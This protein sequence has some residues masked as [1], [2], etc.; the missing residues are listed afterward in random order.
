MLT[1]PCFLPP[2]PPPPISQVNMPANVRGRSH[3]LS[4]L[5]PGQTYALKA[6]DLNEEGWGEESE[7]IEVTMATDAGRRPAP[8]RVLRLSAYTV[9]VRVEEER[10]QSTEMSV[11]VSPLAASGAADA[12][13]SGAVVQCLFR[14]ADESTEDDEED[15][16]DKETQGLTVIP[17][18]SKQCLACS[19]NEEGRLLLHVVP[20][21]QG[22]DVHLD[23]IAHFEKSSAALVQTATVSFGPQA[24][25][26]TT[27][28]GT[29][30]AA[31]AAAA[32]AKK[33]EREEEKARKRR[34]KQQERQEREKRKREATAP[35]Y[36]PGLK[37]VL[38]DKTKRKK[39]AIGQQEVMLISVG[40]AVLAILLIVLLQ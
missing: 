34:A 36:N 4:K 11:R 40:V 27:G 3:K 29:E 19:E 18:S 33:R 2:A 32:A 22:Q 28:D 30:A 20:A 21:K 5:T 15:V 1:W 17:L 35:T 24:T 8:L 26:R 12:A 6:Q 38:K 39:K 14:G 10:G 37:T 23:V 31:A 7:E 13:G 9:A 25:A 16:R